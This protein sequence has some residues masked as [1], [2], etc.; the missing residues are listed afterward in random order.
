[1]NLAQAQRELALEVVSHNAGAWMHDAKRW[2]RLLPAGQ[3][4]GEAIRHWLEPRIGQ[5][6]H[7]N[8]WGAAINAALRAGVIVHTGRYEPMLDPRSHGRRTPVYRRVT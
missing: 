5:P 1:M 3:W 2:M 4:T 7:H 6:H 8:A